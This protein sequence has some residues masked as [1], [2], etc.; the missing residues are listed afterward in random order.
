MKIDSHD[1]TAAK[2]SITDL[3][4][5]DGTIE[6][7]EGGVRIGVLIEPQRFERLML[8]QDVIQAEF[9]E[10]PSRPVDDDEVLTY[11]QLISNII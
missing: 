9:G 6:I 4:S 2:K 5:E 11:H 10:K 3:L 1:L 8:C 7:L